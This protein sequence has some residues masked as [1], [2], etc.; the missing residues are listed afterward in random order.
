MSQT[1]TLEPEDEARANIYGMLAELFIAPPSAGL[2]GQLAAQANTAASKAGSEGNAPSA[3]TQAWQELAQQCAQLS[4]AQ[5]TEEYE[6]LFFSTGRPEI[7][8]NASIYLTGFLNEYPLANLRRELQ[9]LGLERSTA[10]TETE[11]HIAVLC[12]VMQH[13]ILDGQ[14]LGLQA[15]FLH[16]HIG[17]WSDNLCAA[18][19]INASSNFYTRVSAL[20]HAFIS[21]ERE[22][23][24]GQ[25]TASG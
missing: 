5:I 17:N 2:L 22:T 16:A 25:S 7:F 24:P 4:H 1:H 10:S 14:G 19:N 12:N 23:L 11:D 8:L 9:R 15:E 20:L 3:F 13:L 6:Q 21:M 18:I